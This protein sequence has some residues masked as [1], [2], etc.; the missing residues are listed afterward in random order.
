[1]EENAVP[2]HFPTPPPYP[3]L[4]K[5]PYK[6]PLKATEPN[7]YRPLLYLLLFPISFLSPFLLF[8]S[9]PL[10]FFLSLLLFLLLTQFFLFVKEI[11]WN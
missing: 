9:L 4:Y 6:F 1:M 5:G 11:L 3:K 7:L 8:L 10:Y 2:L